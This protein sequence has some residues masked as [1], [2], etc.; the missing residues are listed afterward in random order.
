M[1]A[2]TTNIIEVTDANFSEVV[3][4]HEGLTIVDFWATWCAPCRLI[5]PILDDLATKYASS[6]RIAKLDIDQHVRTTT[7]FNVRSAPTMLFFKNGELV[8]RIIGAVP[9]ARIE[10]ALQSHS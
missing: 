7:R 2:T 3:E 1:S 8:D 5:A 6:V 9:R 10:A 4:K